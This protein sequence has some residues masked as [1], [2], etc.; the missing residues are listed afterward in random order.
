M[1][2]HKPKPVRSWRELLT[3]VG[4]IVLSVCIA[5]AAEQAVE[6]VHWRNEVETARNI[7]RPEIAANDVIF[8]RRIAFR[9]C[10]DRQIAEAEAIIGDL[11]AKRPPGKFTALHTGI[12]QLYDDS[13]WQ[14][15]RASQVL[16]HFPDAELGL[17]TRHYATL[18]AFRLWMDHEGYAWADLS[19][20][21]TPPAGLTAT[22][23]LRLRASLSIARRMNALTV[24]RAKNTL[25][26]S[27]QLGISP[28][29][30]EPERV[31]KFCT[32]SDAEYSAWQRTLEPR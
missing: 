29:V 10:M 24:I 19:V 32:L 20:L 16:T 30:V 6:W 14:S 27:Q 8:A 17:M 2:V 9:P 11:E 21:R 4:I 25:R 31:Q 3:E 1:D 28:P 23:F 22:D 13:Q 5:L 12:E 7:L 15:E 26:I 18:E